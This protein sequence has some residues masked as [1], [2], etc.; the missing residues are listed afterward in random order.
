M[1]GRLSG[2]L[3]GGG[4]EV[5]GGASSSNSPMKVYMMNSNKQSMSPQ[6]TGTGTGFLSG[7]AAK[8]SLSLSWTSSFI[9]NKLENTF[10]VDSLINNR[11]LIA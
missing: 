5:K 2:R 9:K 3:S 11:I 1:S 7:S 6:V 4:G 10:E 8:A